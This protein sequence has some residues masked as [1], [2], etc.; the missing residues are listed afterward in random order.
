LK[1]ISENKL[2][3]I[4][5]PKDISML[6]FAGFPEPKNPKFQGSPGLK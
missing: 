6:F 2:H 3:K 5:S 4:R 1:D